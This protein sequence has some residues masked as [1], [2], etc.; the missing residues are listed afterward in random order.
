MG[1]RG[2]MIRDPGWVAC[3]VLGFGI[4]CGEVDSNF[5]LPVSRAR[6]TRSRE[7]TRQ[8]SRESAG[9]GWEAAKL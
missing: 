7:D 2:G 5:L 9:R 3:C 6:T 8:A 1:F 4:R